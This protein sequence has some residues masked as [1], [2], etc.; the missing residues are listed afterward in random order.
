MNIIRY[1]NNF[2]IIIKYT[3]IVSVLPIVLY[4]TYEY[5]LI[6]YTFQYMCKL[7]RVNYK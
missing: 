1:P 4:F 5:E 3:I 6:K 7:L 2:V